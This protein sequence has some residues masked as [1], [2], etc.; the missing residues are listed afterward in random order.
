MKIID[1]VKK[2]SKT[3]D[4]VSNKIDNFINPPKKNAVSYT[5]TTY[6]TTYPNPYANAVPYNVFKDAYIKNKA[7]S[8]PKS[9][10]VI[11]TETTGLEPEIDRIIEISAIKYINGTPV[12]SFSQLVNPRVQISQFITNLTG[13]TNQELV[14][15]PTIE[16]V[17]PY[18]F[19]FIED[20]VL[21]AH[22]MPF[23]IK[24][25]AC[26]SYRSN[27]RMCEN[28]LLDTVPLIKRV[29]SPTQIPNYKLETLKNFFG[30]NITSHRALA[31]CEMCNIV[32]RHFLTLNEHKNKKL[33]LLDEETGEIIE[34]DKKDW[35]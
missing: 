28:K 15:K 29:I 1:M 10:V 17:L 13:I 6:A 20:Y 24:M 19:Q 16:Y 34:L 26:E 3:L 11:D 22:N 18:F 35:N 25:I 12:A 9:Y 31:D 8:Y 14:N 7:K 27:I 2:A 33:V 21:V 23:D 30:V 32:Y 4:D 5:V